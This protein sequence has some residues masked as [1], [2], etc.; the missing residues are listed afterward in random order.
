[1]WNE[2]SDRF[3]V[4]PKIKLT[5]VSFKQPRKHLPLEGLNEDFRRDVEAYLAMRAQLDLF[6][7][8]P[9]APT[10]KLAASTLQS[11]REH[12]RL[13]ARTHPACVRH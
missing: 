3:E 7:E 8:R 12:L 9:N 10:R 13:A 5:A 1:L 4:W 6:D 2:A 11:Q